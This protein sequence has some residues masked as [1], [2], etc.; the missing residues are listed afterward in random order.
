VDVYINNAL[1]AQRQVPPGPFAIRDL[2]V[3]TGSGQITLVV[4]DLLG[5]EQVLTQA[6]T[7][8]LSLLR[9]GLTDY[10]VEAGA[11]R[12]NYSVQSADYGPAMTAATIRHGVNDKLTLEAHGE[13]SSAISNGGVAAAVLV[14]PLGTVTAQWAQ[15]TSGERSG[16]AGQLHGLG[17]DHA[18]DALSLSLQWQ[19]QTREF[20][21]LGDAG[22]V[23]P[24]RSNLNVA[25]SRSFGR[26]GTLGVAYVQRRYFG[27]SQT[28]IASLN[29]STSLGAWGYLMASL[30]RPLDASGANGRTQLNAIW[31][32]PLGKGTHASLARQPAFDGRDEWVASLQ[33]N[34]PPDTGWSWLAEASDLGNGRA[35]ATFASGIGIAQADAERYSGRVSTRAGVQGGI[36]TVGGTLFMSRPIHDSFALVRLPD[37]PDVRVNANNLAA[38]RTNDRGELL[39]PALRPYERNTVSVEPLDLGLATEI[40]RLSVDVVPFSRSGLVVELPIRRT[41]AVT[42]RLMLDDSSPVPT[43]AQVR[44]DGALREFPVGADGE[45]YISAPRGQHQVEARWGSRRCVAK[46]RLEPGVDPL[47]DLGAVRCENS[48]PASAP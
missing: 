25:A 3:V 31:S 18:A 26:W 36:G 21:R 30:L 43:D 38:G 9:A 23:A 2:P 19:Q 28:R 1:S 13:H 37:L 47:P 41:L 39:L 46:I 20:A 35:Q 45:V 42:L 11:V 48:S 15:S 6:F 8:S 22:Q 33:R 7:S 24:T 14:E 32:I 34:P 4:R 17:L 16:G 5:R 44:I 29:A 40:D 12:R 27:E 10:S